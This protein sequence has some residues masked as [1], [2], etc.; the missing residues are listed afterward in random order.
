VLT[1]KVK[2]CDFIVFL[3]STFVLVSDD[4]LLS[5]NIKHTHF[6]PLKEQRN[7]IGV[8]DGH[9]LHQLTSF[10]ILCSVEW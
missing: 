7:R 5:Q 6:R 10:G 2:V 1:S 9:L 4:G 3:L 8:I